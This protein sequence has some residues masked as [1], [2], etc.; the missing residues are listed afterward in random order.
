VKLASQ[1]R[2]ILLTGEHTSS[3]PSF[4]E[5]AGDLKLMT[6]QTVTRSRGIVVS[7]SGQSVS[8]FEALDS[9]KLIEGE[10]QTTDEH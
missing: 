6:W 9:V 2:G 10:K 4:A 7:R 1:L 5:Q 8:Q 3:M